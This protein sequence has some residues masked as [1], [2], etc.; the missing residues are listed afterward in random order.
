MVRSFGP[1]VLQV[2]AL[3]VGF[4]LRTGLLRRQTGTVRAVDGLSLVLHAGETLG[5]VGESGCGK[6]TSG[7][8]IMGL[9]RPTGGR[10]V[11]EGR[12][13]T[14][15]SRRALRPVRRHIQY[16]FQDPFASL[17]PALT[18]GEAIA[19]P[20]R[21]HRAFDTL[22]GTRHVAEL[23]ERVGL[24]AQ[25]RDR[26]PARIFGGSEATHQHRPRTCAAAARADP[27]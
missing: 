23:L 7:R 14:H 5:L 2:E 17:N 13:I 10:V 1:A 25:R 24:P 20:M 21:I 3:R 12:D 18:V 27:G 26:L 4:P 11:V 9:I 16:V 22:G 6:T 19:E 15:L 8:A